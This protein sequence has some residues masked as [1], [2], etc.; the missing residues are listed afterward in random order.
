LAI[1]PASKSAWVV[2]VQE[3]SEPV[4]FPVTFTV[5][6]RSTVPDAG[7]PI[8]TL[9]VPEVQVPAETSANTAIIKMQEACRT[10]IYRLIWSYIN[11]S[12]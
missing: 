6:D 2:W 3:S 9:G 7:E 10:I 1:V 8:F 4:A 12:G 5:C 11:I